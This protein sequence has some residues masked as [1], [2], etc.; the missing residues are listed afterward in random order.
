VAEAPDHPQTVGRIYK[1]PKGTTDSRWFW[2]M[3]AFGHRVTRIA[4]ATSGWEPS[5]RDAARR[6]ED[7]WAAAQ[8]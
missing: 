2:S 7:A 3:T 8:V 6:A 5:A 4:G 1:G